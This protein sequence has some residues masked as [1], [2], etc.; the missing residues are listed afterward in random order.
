MRRAPE[1][2]TRVCLPGK[3]I[4]IPLDKLRAKAVAL[5]AISRICQRRADTGQPDYAL[6]WAQYEP[7]GTMSLSL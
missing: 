7:S 6:D 5:S 1:W 2:G 4:D 3:E